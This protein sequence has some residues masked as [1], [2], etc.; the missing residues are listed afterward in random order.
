MAAKAE[1]QALTGAS[2]FFIPEVGIATDFTGLTSAVPSA[3]S[4]AD[5]LTCALNND[6]GSNPYEPTLYG[7]PYTLTPMLSGTG[8]L[9]SWQTNTSLSSATNPCGSTDTLNPALANGETN[10]AQFLE[11]QSIIIGAYATSCVSDLASAIGVVQSVRPPGRCQYPSSQIID[12]VNDT[13][14]H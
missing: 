3:G 6:S 10:G 2:S 14:R 7:A 12:T 9:I 13:R 4:N 1:Y 8:T 5:L 11:V